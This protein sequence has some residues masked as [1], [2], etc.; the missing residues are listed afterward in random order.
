MPS[1]NESIVCVHS[2]SDGYSMRPPPI[3][4]KI[5]T[6]ITLMKKPRTSKSSFAKISKLSSTATRS[7][8]ISRSRKRT[9]TVV[10]SLTPGADHR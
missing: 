4:L 9:A 10:P 3:K 5:S 7:T 1:N 6:T 8:R 2:H